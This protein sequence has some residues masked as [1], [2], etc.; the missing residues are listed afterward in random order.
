MSMIKILSLTQHLKDNKYEAF[1]SQSMGG[2]SL[3]LHGREI[4]AQKT[5][6]M[7]LAEK[8][9]SELQDFANR[10]ANESMGAYFQHND[11]AVA[12]RDGIL[13][14]FLKNVKHAARGALLWHFCG[15][16]YG[17]AAKQGFSVLEDTGHWLCGEGCSGSRIPFLYTG[18]K[19]LTGLMCQDTRR[20]MQ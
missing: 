18:F 20:A 4:H 1:S 8:L 2:E 16:S 9:E 6:N 14:T 11:R 7:I 12:V 17:M 10:K 3:I 15:Q 19:I 5:D 13:I